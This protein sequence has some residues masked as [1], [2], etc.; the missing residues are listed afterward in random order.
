MKIKL[1]DNE[2]AIWILKTKGPQPLTILAKEMNV[3]TEGARFQ[4][5]KLAGDGLVSSIT[6]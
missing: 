5:L 2:R 6:E 4:L 3:T 1:P